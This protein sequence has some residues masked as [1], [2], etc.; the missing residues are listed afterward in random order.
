MARTM[1]IDTRNP[2]FPSL[3]YS[4][5]SDMLND[6]VR[7]L[8]LVG[9]ALGCKV[10]VYVPTINQLS[11]LSGTLNLPQMLQKT[12]KPVSKTGTFHFRNHDRDARARR[13]YNVI[14]SSDETLSYNLQ[15]DQVTDNHFFLDPANCKIVDRFQ[16][17][18]WVAT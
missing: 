6:T 7:W 13:P 4:A 3:T 1:G 17:N 16:K 10:P 2:D 14:P 9:I 15:G 5:L 11:Q 12:V 8:G 18:D